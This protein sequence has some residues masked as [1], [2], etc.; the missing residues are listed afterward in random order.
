M[1]KKVQLK[2]E[3]CLNDNYISYLSKDQINIKSI[4]IITSNKN[5][6]IVRLNFKPLFFMI[7][8][9]FTDKF[10][11]NQM[12]CRNKPGWDM[13]GNLFIYPEKDDFSNSYYF[14]IIFYENY[15]VSDIFIVKDI[16]YNN[17]IY[18]DVYIEYENIEEDIFI[19]RLPDSVE[20][21]FKKIYFLMIFTSDNRMDAQ[22]NTDLKYVNKNENFK[23]EKNKNNI[24]KLTLFVND[25]IESLDWDINNDESNEK[26]KNGKIYTVISELPISNFP[27]NLSNYFIY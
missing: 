24:Y 8:S 25:F 17:D 2:K 1:D 23:F 18:E 6:Y 20:S 13:Y 14:D 5:R 9:D 16:M 26:S 22:M 27:P 15:H 21:D 10:I 19:P 7:R 3:I 4:R 12:G 11:R